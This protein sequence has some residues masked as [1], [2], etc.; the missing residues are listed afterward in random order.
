MNSIRVK[1]NRMESNQME[2]KWNSNGP[3]WISNGERLFSN[4][5]PIRTI[6]WLMQGFG[7]DKRGNGVLAVSVTSSTDCHLSN[8]DW[9][10]EHVNMWIE[11]SWQRWPVDHWQ[12]GSR[13]ANQ[14]QMGNMAVEGRWMVINSTTWHATQLS[15]NEANNLPLGAQ[16]QWIEN[17][18]G[19]GEPIEQCEP[20]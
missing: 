19:N 20:N 9:T 6:G 14:R 5:A 12:L 1:W 7:W 8:G 10:C 3:G 17:E 2:M 11:R 16:W 15:D 13:V 18:D 4:S